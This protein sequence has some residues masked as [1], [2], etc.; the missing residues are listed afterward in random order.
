VAYEILQ[1]LIRTH[2]D[3]VAAI[4]PVQR[5][6]AD[7]PELTPHIATVKDFQDL[8]YKNIKRRISNNHTCGG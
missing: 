7:H 4:D 6:V 2:L 8:R 3:T 5:L 1:S